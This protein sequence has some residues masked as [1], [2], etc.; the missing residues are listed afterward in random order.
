MQATMLAGMAAVLAL[1][2]TRAGEGESYTFSK[3]PVNSMGVKCLED[4]RG[5]PVLVD[6]WGTH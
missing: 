3:A 2:A 5:K 4:L 6:F 1:G